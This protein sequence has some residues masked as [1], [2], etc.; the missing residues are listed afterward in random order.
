MTT[1]ENAEEDDTDSA[2]PADTL[3][4]SYPAILEDMKEVKAAPLPFM[5]TSVRRGKANVSVEER[6]PVPVSCP[7]GTPAA[8]LDFFSLGA[9]SILVLYYTITK[10]SKGS[11]S[12]SQ[13]SS[14]RRSFSSAPSVSSAP[15]HP[16]FTAAPTVRDFKPPE[17]TPDDRYP[18][19]YM[20]PS[21]Q[22]AAHDPAYYKRFYDKW[23][24]DY[25]AHVRALEKG[26]IKGFEGA[27][28][29]AEEVNALLEMQKA[30]QDIQE[31]EERKALTAGSAEETAAPK[32]NIKVR[33]LL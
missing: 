13:A 9:S 28:E 12:S 1:V 7:T 11:P 20:L 30:K 15:G 24:K 3:D 4:S 10:Q 21:G 31:R 32:M 33:C 8:D 26:T 29:Q 25:D 23:K 6:H 22:W 18:G 2:P 17:P 5:P 27:E 19:Y 16:S 14:S